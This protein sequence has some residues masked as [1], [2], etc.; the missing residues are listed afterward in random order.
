MSDT[1][2]VGEWDG[3]PATV[4]DYVGCNERPVIHTELS[5]P[6]SEY[7]AEVDLCESHVPELGEWAHGFLVALGV[8]APRSDLDR[9]ARAVLGEH[10]E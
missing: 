1:V 4:C 2:R 3:T 8:I 10:L 5:S 6:E 7:A 9:N